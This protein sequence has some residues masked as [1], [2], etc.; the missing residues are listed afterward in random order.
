[1]LAS[2]YAKMIL[3][4]VAKHGD[5]EVEKWTP[6]KGRHEAPEPTLA[7]RRRYATS[8]DAAVGGVGSFYHAGSDTPAQKGDPVI[9][10]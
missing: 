2:V 3:E 5:V 1:M 8:R 9:R 4:L 10:V 7:F 6:A